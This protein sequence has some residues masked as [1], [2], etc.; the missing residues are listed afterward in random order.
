MNQNKTKKIVLL[1]MAWLLAGCGSN[2]A[3]L[4]EKTSAASEAL[5]ASESNADAGTQEA[6]S[7][8]MFAMDTYMTMTAYGNAAQAALDA[9]EA[10]IHEL[11]TLLSTGDETSEVYQL[12]QSGEAVLSE[13][14][15]ALMDASLNL[16]QKTGGAFDIAIYPMMSLWG[17]PTQEYRVPSED[18]IERTLT[19][20]DASKLTYE[21]EAGRIQ[22]Q[23]EG[24]AIDF[25]GIAKG[26]TSQKLMQLFRDYGVTSALV[27]LGGN[28]E[29]LGSK[30][31]GSA[32]NVAVRTPDDTGNILG[33]I[34][35]RD[36]A[37]ITSGGYERYFEQD[38]RT[39]HHILDPATGKPSESGLTSVTI[40]SSDGTMA[41]GLS[42]SLFIMGYD[43][44]VAFWR[45]AAEP[46]EM[47][48]V[49]ENGRISATEGLIDR[50]QS[51]YEITAITKQ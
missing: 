20:S 31:D 44:A 47:I 46:F 26:Y 9:G 4:Q 32:W 23:E 5:E 22:F 6:V 48:L 2:P 34:S 7:R 8:E 50:L 16:Y 21:K 43:K 24:M 37:V 27:N 29:A 30:P 51:E 28:V 19:I 3:V 10:Q 15:R 36:E 12:N 40:V 25:G 14:G 11:D 35:V 18:E 42:T 49:E 33:V 13:D 17:F 41:D 1:G 39:Y 45:E 38:G